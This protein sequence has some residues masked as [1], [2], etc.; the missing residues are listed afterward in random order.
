MRIVPD[1]PVDGYND[2]SRP[3]VDIPD[4]P[5]QVGDMPDDEL[6]ELFNTFTAW[7]DYLAVETAKKSAVEEYH[8]DNLT[9]LKA[10]YILLGSN[11]VTGRAQADVAPD[12][13]DL[14]RRLR[15]AKN[16]RKLLEAKFT[17]CDRN[18]KALS[19]ELTRRTTVA[20]GSRGRRYGP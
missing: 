3:H 14:R 8:E 19:R 5:L 10:N 15:T 4:M 11:T 7:A 17:N 6:M 13:R 9:E 18:A 1:P 12:V 20:E 16:V 2:P